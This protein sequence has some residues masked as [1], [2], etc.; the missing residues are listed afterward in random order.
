MDY[1]RVSLTLTPNEYLDTSKAFYEMAVDFQNARADGIE[2]A[3]ED[4][5]KQR[6]RE[7]RQQAALTNLRAGR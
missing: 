6:E 1:L 4:E 2:A 3:R 5:R 7:A